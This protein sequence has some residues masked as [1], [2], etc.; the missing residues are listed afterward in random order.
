VLNP[1]GLDRAINAGV[2]EVNVVVVASETFSQNNQGMSSDEAMR[3]FESIAD[4]ARAANLGV[5]VTIG[6]TFGCPFEG[7]VD[8]AVVIEMARRANEIGVDELA[9]A[10]TIGV[11]VPANIR[12][13]VSGVQTVTD[14]NLVLGRLAP[15]R[16]L[17]GEMPLDVAA[18]EAA[19]QARVAGPLGI[20]LTDAANGII[21]IAA[22]TMSHVVTR[23]TTE[24][25][26][27]AGD[28]AMVAYGGAGPLHA[29]LVA[30]ELRIPTVIIPP[31][32]GHF[33]AYGML[34]ADLRRDFPLLQ[35][36][37]P[38]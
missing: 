10:D 37:L 11:A 3:N 12:N 32:P 4:R 2:D 20:S 19:L 36:V 16:F 22:S 31:A 34:M 13:V 26:L 27:D 24:R 30:R 28:F 15:D 1:R 8:P 38:P 9:L 29:G 23:V 25:G 5:S 21:R 7:E 17:G 33:S 6:A 14:A 18:A 35:G